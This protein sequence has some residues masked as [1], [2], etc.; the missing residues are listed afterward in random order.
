MLALSLFI[1]PGVLRG[2]AS[3]RSAHYDFLIAIISSSRPPPMLEAV[4][5]FFDALSRMLP[6]LG[7]QKHKNERYERKNRCYCAPEVPLVKEIEK[8]GRIFFATHGL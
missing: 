7:L 1:S 2:L 5:V 8:L 6:D 3:R 4:S